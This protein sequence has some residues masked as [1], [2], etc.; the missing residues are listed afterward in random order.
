M[1]LSF[2]A[3]A[4]LICILGSTNAQKCPANC[5]T[6]DSA[7]KC[8]SCNLGFGVN[9]GTCS[10]C[11]DK[12]CSICPANYKQCTEC[13][14]GALGLTPTGSCATCVIRRCARCPTDFK[15]CEQCI[16]GFTLDNSGKC[17]KCPQANCEY[18]N[19]SKCVRCA[20]TYG[21]TPAGTCAKC[22]SKNCVLCNDNV[23][24]CMQCDLG[25]GWPTKKICEKCLVKNCNSCAY[26]NKKC[27]ECNDGFGL[28]ASRSRCVVCSDRNCS[29]CASASFC[30]FCKT[31]Y[32]VRGG[33]CVKAK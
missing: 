18:C 25:F 3:I 22:A 4:I 27:D 28:D 1:K 13:N 30:D 2:V 29:E 6:C 21:V 8:T 23:N 11:S 14:D 19:T 24:L 26:N 17:I 33:K 7:G 20:N 15:K 16:E 9:A 5:G 10:P 31:G 12:N 32:L